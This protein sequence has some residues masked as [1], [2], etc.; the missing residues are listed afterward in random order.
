MPVIAGAMNTTLGPTSARPRSTVAPAPLRSDTRAATSRNVPAVAP[1]SCTFRLI[2]IT[3][4]IR[5][6]TGLSAAVSVVT[7]VVVVVA[8]VLSEEF[9]TGLTTPASVFCNVESSKAVTGARS[10]GTAPVPEGTMV[11]LPAAK[12]PRVPLYA[13]ES[14]PPSGPLHPSA[15][16]QIPPLIVTE[17]ARSAVDSSELMLVCSV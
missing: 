15:G 6:K 8:T 17:T 5:T 3:V 14:F 4:P 10:A 13:R 11:A 2:P 9:S 16:M 7:A 12:S 1:D